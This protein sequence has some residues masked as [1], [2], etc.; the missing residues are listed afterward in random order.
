MPDEDR[1][2]R[3]LVGVLLQRRV[4]ANQARQR[5][6]HLARVEASSRTTAPSTTTGFGKVIDSSATGASGSHSVWPVK[7]CFRPMAATMSPG[8]ADL[9]LQ[10]LVAH[11]PVE[12]DDALGLVDRRVEVR[13]ARLEFARVDADVDQVAGRF[14]DGLERQRRERLLGVGLAHDHVLGLGMQ[15]LDRRAVERAR[16]AIDDEV[17]QLLHA[18]VHLRRAAVDRREQ[19]VQRPLA[20]RLA[21]QV[22]GD[23][24]AFEDQ[25]GDLVGRHRDGV[26]QFVR[27]ASRPRPCTSR[28]CRRRR[29]S[30]WSCRPRRG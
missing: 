22:L 26:E 29:T 21:D 3:L 25:L 14:G 19:P 23:W 8:P 7:V 16:Q 4:V 5:L 27:G 6:A 9:Q 30:G 2:L 24:L 13:P 11:H 17:E 10:P 20:E 15:P 1:L 28:G 12:A 18:L